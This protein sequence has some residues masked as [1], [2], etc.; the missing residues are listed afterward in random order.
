MERVDSI[1]I[2][3][4]GM[5]SSL[6]SDVRTCC[7]AA[8]AGLSRAQELPY[9]RYKSPETGE[10]KL[11]TGHWAKHLTLGFESK[12]R[13]I[14]LAEGALRDFMNNVSSNDLKMPRAKWFLSFP[15]IGRTHSGLGLVFDEDIKEQWVEELEDL[16]E[17]VDA[18][19]YYSEVIKKAAH[20]VN[21][22]NQVDISQISV[23][24]QP[25]CAEMLNYALSQLHEG[26]I[27]YAIVGGVDS[28]LDEDTLEWLDTTSRLKRDGIPAGVIPGE[29]AAF[30]LLE[31]MSRAK[32]QGRKVWGVVVAVEQS[33]EPRTFIDGGVSSGVG[34]TETLTRL[35]ARA[36]SATSS[37]VLVI[38]DQNGESYRAMEWGL[39]LGRLYTRWQEVANAAMW[40]PAMWFGDTGAAYGAI[41]ICVATCAY[42]RGYHLSSAILVVSA[43]DG[44]RRSTVLL[45]KCG[46]DEPS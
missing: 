14:R 4:M 22:P 21:W 27:D 45:N 1:C 39:C 5:V 18:F 11:A 34:Q 28:L 40:Y 23:A 6:G 15:E 32:S 17:R 43:S 29:G 44:A 19:E 13:L 35:A 24:G 20:L 12:A 37:S 2:T 30:L 33:Q 25:G 16:G 8:R 36:R 10:N 9:F 41:S 38:S 26:T 3:G 31:R 42:E 7:A 46:D